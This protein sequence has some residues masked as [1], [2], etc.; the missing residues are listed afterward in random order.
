MQQCGSGLRGRQALCFP[1]ATASCAAQTGI[2]C[3]Y[4]A[5]LAASR[6][7]AAATR[8]RTVLEYVVRAHHRILLCTAGQNQFMFHKQR[9]PG[10]EYRYSYQILVARVI[11]SLVT[12]IKI[13]LIT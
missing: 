3:G 1:P 6:A 12:Q 8:V 11:E 2:L 7:R 10:Y 4:G 13:L 9:Y 5:L